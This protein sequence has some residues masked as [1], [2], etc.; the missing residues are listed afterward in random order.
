MKGLTR[1][2]LE[3][4]LNELTVLRIN[5]TFTD[6]CTIIS[7]VIEKRMAYPV[8]VHTDLVCTS[9]LKTALDNSHITESFENLIVCHSMLAIVSVREHLEAHSVVRVTA[10]IADDCTLVLLKVT[11]YNSHITT[12]D[13]VHE[14]LLCKIKLCLIILGHN[15]KS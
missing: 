6:L 1:K 10:D 4:V 13:R 15:E 5:S 11:P 14:E 8:E 12:L 2:K 3:A 9:S 7:F